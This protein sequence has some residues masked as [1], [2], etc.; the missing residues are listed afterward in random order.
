MKYSDNNILTWH[1]RFHVS[2]W[3]GRGV[4]LISES[5]YLFL[6]DDK[7]PYIQAIDG[8]HTAEEIVL[9]QA[10][11]DKSAVFFYQTSQLRQKGYL[12]S[13]DS[14][15][16]SRYRSGCRRNLQRQRLNAA[17]EMVNLSSIDSVLSRVW[18]NIIKSALTDIGK[19]LTVVLVDDFLEP[20]LIE[21]LVALPAYCIIKVTGEKI[22]ISP[23]STADKPLYWP[24][25]Q[26]QLWQNQPVRNLV[27]KLYPKQEH[28]LPF[29]LDQPLT[30]ENIRQINT[31]L[32]RQYAM[33]SQEIGILA[34]SANE[35]EYHPVNPYYHN[36]DDFSAQISKAVELKPCPILFDL[37]GGCRNI[38][39]EQ[40][41]V[42]LSPL[43]SPVS[44]V[45]T[46]IE[47]LKANENQPVKTFRTAFFKTPVL[48]QPGAVNE[49]FVQVCM[50]KGV[51]TTQSKVSALCE[52]IERYAA[53]YQGD[54]P[55]LL[56][57]QSQLDKRSYSPSLLVPYSEQQYLNFA[58]KS[59]QDSSL[60]QAA[61]P[62]LDSEIHWLPG[63]SLCRN[64]Q[65]YLP[66]TACF[67]NT[68]FN[69]E[70]FGRWHSNG[71]AAGNT[72]EEAVLQGLFE[73]IERDAT[74]LWWY[75][76][77]RGAEFDLER[78]PADN[79][80][81]L[82]QTLSVSHHYWVLDIT[83]DIGVPVM[84]AIGQDLKTQGYSLG[85]GCHLQPELAAQRALTELCQL[86]PIRDQNGAPFDFDA[87]VEGEYLHPDINRQGIPAF[88]TS[89]GDI[90][91]DIENIVARIQSL[92]YET[93]VVNYS[94]AHLPIK[95]AK[96]FVPGLCHIWPQLANTRL[97]KLPVQLGWLQ[98]EKTEATINQQALYI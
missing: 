49:S 70:Q 4:I 40:T 41:L 17:I 8:K 9:A 51:S 23:V 89:C 1:P 94:R 50:G 25:L 76:Q 12:I 88:T 31:L 58:D 90:K 10:E 44:G 68:P 97:Y 80:K 61:K 7:F 71:C 14:E 46:H 47:E 34:L 29:M 59:H 92:G 65:V 56:S 6:P 66:L 15:I 48:S 53:L 75:N 84:V 19:A 2:F 27:A 16:H 69:D 79:L 95:T 91:G 33:K 67:A 62:Y 42:N 38:S 87:I 63:W 21:V 72:L 83:T 35:I 74:A 45:I 54:E 13:A 37:D 78:I 82:Q 86:I 96:V 5:E 36:D 64:E 3:Q 93:L 60:K 52:T 39:P 18:G 30:S 98:H 57:R 22:W 55:L 24:K 20:E 43:I 28:Q 32:T 77:T 11:P 26:G 73:L 85:L 81:Q